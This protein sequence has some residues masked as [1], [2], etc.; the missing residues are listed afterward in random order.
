MTA[1]HQTL[2]YKR[3]EFT[4]LGKTGPLLFRRGLKNP[5]YRAAFVT[6]KDLRDLRYVQKRGRPGHTEHTVDSGK[7]RLPVL[8]ETGEWSCRPTA[9]ALLVKLLRETDL[10]HIGLRFFLRTCLPMIQ[11]GLFRS[12]GRKR[13]ISFGYISRKRDGL[14]EDGKRFVKHIK[15]CLAEKAASC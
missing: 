12:K 4:E 15:K 10:C 7:G 5:F 1:F 9:A 8:S 3:L 14:S 13:G 2:E 11:Y 6:G